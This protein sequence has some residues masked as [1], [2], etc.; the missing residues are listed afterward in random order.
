M[1]IVVAIVL[2]IVSSFHV[3]HEQVDFV[4]VGEPEYNEVIEEYEEELFAQERAQEPVGTNFADLAPAQG[5]PRCI[6]PIFK[7]SLNI[8]HD[9]HLC[10]RHFMETICI[11]IPTM[12]PTSTGRCIWL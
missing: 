6:I 10:Y 4:P 3:D 2:I 12:S 1:R 11:T 8:L 9:L 5:K 7:W